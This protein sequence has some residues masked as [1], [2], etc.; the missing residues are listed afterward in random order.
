MS[1]VMGISLYLLFEWLSVL[2]LL[3]PSALFF[4]LLRHFGKLSAGYERNKR[5][6]T[7]IHY[8]EVFLMVFM[9]RYAGCRIASARK[10]SATLKCSEPACR[11]AGTI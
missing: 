7:F 8:V 10:G 4:S 6:A 5:K 11:Q 1:A 3:R 9:S 2:I